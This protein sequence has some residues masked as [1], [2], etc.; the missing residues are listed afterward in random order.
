MARAGAHASSHGGGG[1]RFE[2]KQ[3]RMGGDNGSNELTRTLLPPA[4][5]LTPFSRASCPLSLFFSV[6]HARISG[7]PSSLRFFPRHSYFA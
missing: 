3:G 6:F 7:A 5:P 4:A 1:S 2:S